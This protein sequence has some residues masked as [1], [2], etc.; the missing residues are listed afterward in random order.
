MSELRIGIW[1]RIAVLTASLIGSI[2][3]ASPASAQ[4]A[5]EIEAKW[6]FNGS[7]LTPLRSLSTMRNAVNAE[8]PMAGTYTNAWRWSG[9]ARYFRDDYYDKAG[10]CGTLCAASHTLR[11]RTRLRSSPTVTSKNFETLIGATWV[12][13]W[14]K[15]QY[16]STPHRT[17]AIWSRVESG[18]CQLNQSPCNF[19]AF[20][21]I[22]GRSVASNHDAVRALRADHPNYNFSQNIHFGSS[23]PDAVHAMRERI[24]LSANSQEMFE[25]S[26]D[27]VLTAHWGFPFQRFD[28]VEVEMLRPSFG[29]VDLYDMMVIH[30]AFEDTYDI[31]ASTTS[32]NGTPVGEDSFFGALFL[33]FLQANY[34]GQ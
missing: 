4:G 14:Q 1:T 34:P 13:D 19:T 26:I 7:S 28:E 20:D 8:S 18:D 17:Q 25:V 16:K 9:N 5:L 32:K 23:A 29:Y 30:V 21:V 11:H 24:V 12:E 15:V 10:T 3:V 33:A 22:Y 31:T 2:T 27:Q 6:R